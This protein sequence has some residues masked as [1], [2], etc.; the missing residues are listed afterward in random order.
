MQIKI[1]TFAFA[2]I[3]LVVFMGACGG[4]QPESPE[5]TAEQPDTAELPPGHPPMGQQSP[6]S[7]LPT[8]VMTEGAAL[9][10]TKPADWVDEPPANPMRQAQFRVSGPGG[11]GVCVVYYFGA[12]QGGGPQANAERW[13]DQFDQPDGS[14][15]REALVTEAIEVGGL[16]VLLVQVSGIYREGGMMMTGG[17]QQSFPGYALEGAIVEGPDANWFFKFTGPEETVKA[18]SEQFRALIDS[19]QGPA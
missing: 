16:P 19:V 2:T 13:A 7:T 3:L 17:P 4:S 6:T 8:P 10:W 1:F 14:S 12:G 5:Q 11:D 15:S 9:T 18:H